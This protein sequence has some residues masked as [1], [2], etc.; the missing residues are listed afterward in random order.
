MSLL[1]NAGRGRPKR[2]APTPGAATPPAAVAPPELGRPGSRTAS[3]LL[4]C[5]MLF[6]HENPLACRCALA[7]A[8]AKPFRNGEIPL[9]TL[10]SPRLPAGPLGWGFGGPGTRSGCSQ[11]LPGGDP[12]RRCQS[13]SQAA[14]RLRWCI[15]VMR[16]VGRRVPGG[17]AAKC[18]FFKR[19]LCTP[20]PTPTGDYKAIR[21]LR[22][23]DTPEYT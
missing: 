4:R 13:G 19:P 15:E 3:A 16:G 12:G 5:K 18:S 9:P 23:A 22:P 10:F 7:L 11:G 14:G 17:T 20:T 2:R 8:G 1:A 21:A 6:Y